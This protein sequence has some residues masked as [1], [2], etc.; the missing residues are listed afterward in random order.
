MTDLEF[1][2]ETAD[3]ASPF[4]TLNEWYEQYYIPVELNLT[5]NPLGRTWLTGYVLV[6]SVLAPAEATADQTSQAAIVLG[7]PKQSSGETSND[8]DRVCS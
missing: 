5:K 7:D 1:P 3:L 8:Q 6:E 2:F 4:Q